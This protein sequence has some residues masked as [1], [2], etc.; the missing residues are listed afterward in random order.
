MMSSSCERPS[1]A[2]AGSVTGWLDDGGGWWAGGDEISRQIYPH[3]VL[4]GKPR[5][6]LSFHHHHQTKSTANAQ[7][8]HQEEASNHGH[9]DLL[10]QD[11][12]RPT[13][14]LLSS[15]TQLFRDITTSLHIPLGSLSS[16]PLTLINQSINSLH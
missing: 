1:P 6:T 13:K 4:A 9:G 8:S 12:P 16:L 5:R 10:Y 2:F 11:G 15:P 14:D 3:D 7:L